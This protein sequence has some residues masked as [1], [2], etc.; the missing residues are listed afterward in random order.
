MATPAASS[1]RAARPRAWFARWRGLVISSLT[2]LLLL[3]CSRFAAPRIEVVDA[4]VEAQ[5][6]IAVQIGLVVEITNPNDEPIKLLACDYDLFVE[7][8]RVYGGRRA[9]EETLNQRSR[10]RLVFPAVVRYEQLHW[11]QTAPPSFAYRVSGTLHYSTPGELAETL[12][13]TG[14]RRPKQGFSGKGTV[15]AD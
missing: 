6:D 2:P 13:D 4:S 14:L 11:P 1:V 12:L 5:T 10:R 9:S 15:E 7:G 3:G 8:Q